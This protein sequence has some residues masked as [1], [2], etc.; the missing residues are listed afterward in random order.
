MR[1]GKMIFETVKTFVSF[2]K[3]RKL[4]ESLARQVACRANIKIRSF[5]LYKVKIQGFHTKQENK[6]HLIKVS[7]L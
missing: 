2:R 6:M 7:K 3:T 1:E 4:D 5:L